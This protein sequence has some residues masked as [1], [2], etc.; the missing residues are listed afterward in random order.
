MQNRIQRNK[1]FSNQWPLHLMVIPGLLILLVYQYGPMLGIA[2]AFQDFIPATGL[3]N[4]PW[5]GLENFRYMFSL[6]NFDTVIWNTFYISLLKVIAGQIFPITIAIL[7]NEIRIRFMM[8]SIQTLI[9]LPHFLSW[10]ILGGI[11]IDILSPSYGMV[12]GF[13]KWLG[14]EPIFFLGDAQLFPYVLVVSDLW[15]DFGFSTIVYLA[16]ITSVNPS[17]YEAAV[18]DGA[19]WLRR[20]WHVTLPG[21]AP[22]IILLATLSIGQILNAG[23]EQVFNLYS[24][25]VYETGDIIDTFVYRIGLVQA[26]YALATAVGLLKSVIS[27]VLIATSY[28]LAYRLANYRIF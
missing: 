18:V 26:Q 15:K 23:F 3:F 16:A 1:R 5:V 9:Y 8:R 19:T 4:S 25:A 2:I 10:V 6:P 27:L 17:L 11:L 14:F 13:I 28:Y 21:M 12:N 22:I 20:T 24:P 7:L